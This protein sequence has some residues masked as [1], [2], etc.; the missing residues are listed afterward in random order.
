MT[1]DAI[2]QWV[3]AHQKRIDETIQDFFNKQDNTL[4]KKACEYTLLNGGKRLRSL[5]IYAIGE[6]EKILNKF[7]LDQLALSIELIHAYSLTH[8]DLPQMDDDDLRRGKPSCHIEFNEGQ[9]ILAGDALQSLAFQVLSNKNL[10]IHNDIKIEIINILSQSIGLNGMA[11]G[12][13]M[14]IALNKT[15][16]SI[17]VLE[18]LQELKTGAL[19]QAACVIPFLLS[20]NYDEIGITDMANIGHL[21]GKIYQITDDILDV[22][23]NTEIL[24]KTSGKDKKNNK[25]TYISLVGKEEALKIKASIFKDLIKSIEQFP[26]KLKILQSLVHHIYKRAY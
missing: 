12:Q 23:S 7:H 11:L 10:N 14:D 18:K 3:L 6:D 2:N 1:K 26:R 15:N 22:E 8:D 25:M 13:S 16:S 24:G 19:I 17:G 9:A 5:L 20:K 21:I 4:L